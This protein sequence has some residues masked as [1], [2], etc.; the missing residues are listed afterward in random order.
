[1]RCRLCASPRGINPP[2]I[3]CELGHEKQEMALKNRTA[4]YRNSHEIALR[5]NC[6]CSIMNVRHRIEFAGPLGARFG[7]RD[8]GLGSALARNHLSS[9]QPCRTR[10]H[11][12]NVQHLRGPES[13]ARGGFFNGSTPR[14]RCESPAQPV[15]PPEATTI[16]DRIDRPTAPHPANAAPF[17]LYHLLAPRAGLAYSP[18]NRPPP[19]TLFAARI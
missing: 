2:T 9:K 14:I 11:A 3:D 15:F 6:R 12:T 8:P 5:C 16:A 7:R 1:M 10:A 17:A 4:M 19:G 13:R 18:E